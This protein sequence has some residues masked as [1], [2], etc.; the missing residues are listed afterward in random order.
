MPIPSAMFSSKSAIIGRKW[1]RKCANFGAKTYLPSPTHG[2]LGRKDLNFP[3][4]RWRR[5]K[6]KGEAKHLLSPSP[7]GKHT[8]S[9]FVS[10]FPCSP[11]SRGK[12]NMEVEANRLLFCA[13]LALLVSFD[14]VTTESS[15][16]T[17]ASGV[18]WC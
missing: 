3:S 4:T 5:E 13:P 14:H 12:P 1:F 6:E 9:H 11:L 18:N 10:L 15:V 8:V 2:G 16:Y 7:S 17:M